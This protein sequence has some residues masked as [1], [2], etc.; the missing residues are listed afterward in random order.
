MAWIFVADAL[1]CSFLAISRLSAFPRLMAWIFITAAISSSAFSTYSAC[2][3]ASFSFAAALSTFPLRMA[4]IFVAATLSSSFLALV[5]S[6]L[7][8]SAASAASSRESPLCMRE[9][10]LWRLRLGGFLSP[11]DFP[12]WLLPA[13]PLL[14][15]CLPLAARVA[16]GSPMVFS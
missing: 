8:A 14:M 13:L 11:L 4:W 12:C 9:A 2:L 10:K 5:F 16:A 6:T 7:S 15:T 3:A 1:S